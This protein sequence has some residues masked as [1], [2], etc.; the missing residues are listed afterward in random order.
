MSD[1]NRKEIHAVSEQKN[2]RQKLVDAFIPE[3]VTNVGQYIL[4]DWILPGI[5]DFVQ[6]GL[7]SV[8][9]KPGGGSRSVTPSMTGKPTRVANITSQVAYNKVFDQKNARVMN[10]IGDYTSIMIPSRADAEMVL[11]EM[12][13]LIGDEEIG[14]DGKVTIGWFF[15]R[16]GLRPIPSEAWNWGWRDLRNAR[17]E[18]YNNGYRIVFPRAIS[19][20]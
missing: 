6:T 9:H 4:T 7:N 14:G 19:L 1:N 13:Y 16:C 2:F 12:R 17:V 3:D 5:W 18:R 8:I 20:R 15:D 11:E 10:D